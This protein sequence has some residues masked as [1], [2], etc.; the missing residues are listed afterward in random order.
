MTPKET[1]E[2]AC[3]AMASLAAP[4]GTETVEFCADDARVACPLFQAE[5]GGPAMQG[6]RDG[7]RGKS[8]LGT[9]PARV[10]EL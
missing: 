2:L 1:S 8:A 10:P 5:Y 9:N 3:D 4:S 7:E 6:T